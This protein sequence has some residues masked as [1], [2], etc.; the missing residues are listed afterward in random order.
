MRASP[1]AE[2][3][4]SALRPEKPWLCDDGRGFDS[5]HLHHQCHV[6]APQL[7]SAKAAPGEIRGRPSSCAWG[8]RC[9]LGAPVAGG[10]SPLGR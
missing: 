8:R 4:H 6:I 1:G 9:P 3:I 2:K 5:R 10:V 7:R